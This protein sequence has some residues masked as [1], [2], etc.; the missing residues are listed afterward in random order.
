MLSRRAKIA[1]QDE[2]RVVAWGRTAAHPGSE[3]TTGLTGRQELRLETVERF[4]GYRMA[5][6]GSVV[7]GYH[8]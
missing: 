3:L 2:T 6:F 5:V 4:L 1:C 8:W 7:N